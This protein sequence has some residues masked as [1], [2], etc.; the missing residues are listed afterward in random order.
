M[1][2]FMSSH[3]TMDLNL[4]DQV[5]PFL[6]NVCYNMS[7]IWPRNIYSIYKLVREENTA[8]NY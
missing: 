6:Y 1:F 5:V 3:L 4:Q 8:P 7:T 2:H